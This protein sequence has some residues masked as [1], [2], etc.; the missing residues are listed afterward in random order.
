MCGEASIIYSYHY[1]VFLRVIT[2][3]EKYKLKQLTSHEKRLKYNIILNSRR[4]GTTLYYFDSFSK[5]IPI[6]ISYSYFSSVILL[7]FLIF[8]K[9]FRVSKLIKFGSKCFFWETTTSVIFELQGIRSFP[10]DKYV[11]KVEL[12]PICGL[13]VLGGAVK[14]WT[15][16]I[17]WRTRNVGPTVLG[18]EFCNTRKEKDYILGLFWHW[19][20]SKKLCYFISLS[21]IK[22]AKSYHYLCYHL[23]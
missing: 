1:E 13:N 14:H 9:I 3:K 17:D 21:L 23:M 8:S 16:N 5:R 11:L 18:I 2:K 19:D 12:V 22:L 4:L 6:I 20:F 15:L 7:G 10:M